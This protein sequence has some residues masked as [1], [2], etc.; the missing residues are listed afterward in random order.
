MIE[1]K[2]SNGLSSHE[3]IS[4]LASRLF[5]WGVTPAILDGQ[6]KGRRF[7]RLSPHG[8]ARW[9]AR[10]SR[11]APTRPVGVSFLNLLLSGR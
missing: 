9:I 10:S 3:R 2:T 4:T 6:R 8:D 11:G 7:R 5:V 1:A